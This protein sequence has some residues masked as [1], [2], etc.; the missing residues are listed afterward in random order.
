MKL[1]EIQ[2]GE[3]IVIDT[4]IL[5]YANQQ[6][7]RQCSQLL[8]RC[9]I[10]EVRGIVPMPMVVELVHILIMIEARD[11][12][13]IKQSNPAQT[14]SESPELIQR[15]GRYATQ[16]REFLGIGLRIESAISYD[17]IEAL[18]IQREYGLLPNKALLLAIAR[19]LNC[20]AIASADKALEKAKGFLVYSPRDIGE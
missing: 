3:L 16:I 5:V 4:N 12:N 1:S 20:D 17:I 6:K 15:L 13:W 19:R 2:K 18:N 11:N 9:A 14:F 7:S 8:R 10:G